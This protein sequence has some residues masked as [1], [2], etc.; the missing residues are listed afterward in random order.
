M[1]NLALLQNDPW[2]AVFREFDRDFGRRFLA[3]DGGQSLSPLEDKGE[4]YV[5]HLSVPGWSD[6]DFQIN[7]T[8][9]SLEITGERAVDPPEGYRVLRQE[10]PHLRFSRTFTLPKK[11]DVESTSATLK[12]GVLTVH[13][14]KAK[15]TQPRSIAVKVGTPSQE[16][17]S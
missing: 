7:A 17:A 10:R 15:E 8:A 1:L 4:T 2:T 16:I 6:K 12:D 13:L 9:D 11:V 5:L 3:L 14:K